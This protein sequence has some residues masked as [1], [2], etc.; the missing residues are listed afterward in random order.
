MGV[1]GAIIGLLLIIAIL[2]IMKY[3]EVILI[4]GFILMILT[5]IISAIYFAA[6]DNRLKKVVRA[7]IICQ[8]PIIETISEKTGHTKSYGYYY[9]YHEH[10]RDRD[11][12]SGYKVTFSVEFE[13]GKKDTIT[14]K[15]GSYTYRK[16]IEKM[17]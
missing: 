14:C 3:F 5:L 15:E 9:T 4:V 17:Q 11:V 16:L 6:H 10:F 8:D 13:N 12:I 2:F 7:H 1:I